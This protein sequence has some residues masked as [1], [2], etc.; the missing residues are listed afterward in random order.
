[1]AET[2]R[3]VTS[4]ENTP[5]ERRDAFRLVLRRARSRE[6]LHEL[7]D[8]LGLTITPP[9]ARKR[10]SIPATTTADAPINARRCPE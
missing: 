1:M 9:V 3:P 7:L 2:P 8:A 5:E 4:R 10:A 6:D